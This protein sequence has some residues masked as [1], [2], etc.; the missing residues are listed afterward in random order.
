MENGK[1]VPT[2]AECEKM[3][4]TF[5]ECLHAELCEKIQSLK[6]FDRKNLAYCKGFKRAADVAP[7]VH[8]DWV[9]LDECSNEGV[10]CSV[11]HKKV[12]KAC[13]ANQKIKSKF[14]PNCG[15]RMDKEDT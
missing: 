5:G 14:C 9:L 15:A 12:Y 7:V 11:C 3:E 1:K 4:A 8:G 6:G 2:M 13:Y 10:Y